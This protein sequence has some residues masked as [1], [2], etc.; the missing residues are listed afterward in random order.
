MHDMSV[1]EYL[2]SSLRR[3]ISRSGNMRRLA[4]ER[5]MD[6]STI[7]RFNSGRNDLANMPVK[8]LLRLFPDLTLYCFPEDVPSYRATAANVGDAEIIEEL[9]ELVH[10]LPPR[11]KLKLLTTVASLYGN[12]AKS[13][14]NAR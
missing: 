7:N 9:A 14:P 1:L 6:Y 10:R 3:A 5:G 2:K 11:E 13:A 4:A 12:G 8:T